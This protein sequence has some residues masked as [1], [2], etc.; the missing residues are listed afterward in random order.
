MS[1]THT[2]FNSS[3][4]LL[5]LTIASLVCS[6]A[7]AD[8]AGRV[9]FVLGAVNAI[10]L[11]GSTRKLAKSDLVYSGERL[12][13]GRGRLQ[14]RFTDGSFVSLQP[15]TVFRLDSYSFDKTAPEQGSLQFNFLRGGLRTVT[16]AIGKVNRA[17]YT[18]RSPVATIGIRGTG[19]ATTL[20]N[21]VLTL[22]V[23]KGIVNLSN[24][25]G[26][27]NISAGQT[28]QVE[29]GEAPHLAPPGV[30]AV[31]LAQTPDANENQQDD[32]LANLI[33]SS[34]NNNDMLAGELFLL[35]APE[36]LSPVLP[37]S[38][39]P[40]QSATPLPGYTFASRFYQNDNKLYINQ[41]GGFFNNSNDSA[42]GGLLQLTTSASNRISTLFN[43]G[44][45][46]N[47]GLH[48]SH[49]RTLGALSFGEWTNGTAA[50]GRLD[51]SDNNIVLGA[52]EFEPYIIGLNGEASLGMDNQGNAIKLNYSL[53]GA[54]PARSTN[55]EIG[56][57]SALN[58]DLT[59]SPLVMMNIFMTVDMA[60]TGQYSLSRNN[61]AINNGNSNTLNSFQLDNGE[62][63][64]TGQNCAN[65]GCPVTL[66]A[67]LAGQNDLGA[68]YTI[69]RIGDQIGG[70]GALT[71]TS[72]NTVPVKLVDT[73]TPNYSAVFSGSADR[74]LH[75]ENSIDAQFD[76]MGAW[77]SGVVSSGNAYGPAETQSANKAQA[78][79]T[80]HVAQTLA[81]GRWANG[82]I[83]CGGSTLQLNNDG[84]HYVVGT[85]TTGNFPTAKLSYDL[86]GGTSPTAAT[87]AGTLLAT[88]NLQS[89]TV[90]IDFGQQTATLQMGLGFNNGSS[91]T[92]I[93]VNGTGSLDSGKLSFNDMTVSV[94]TG[95]NAPVNC[96]NC[97]ANASG[98]VA[99]I[100]ADMVGI[101]YQVQGVTI[102]Q[103]SNTT[104]TGVG[105]FANKH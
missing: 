24:D 68:I 102:G 16:G 47:N 4:R 85:P 92:G 8:I 63:R 33:N 61:I 43:A 105:A 96:S 75:R 38:R 69:D 71:E 76:D 93:N 64:A 86:V 1:G 9:S 72:T 18:V 78:V 101:G 36:E 23:D 65:G 30:N 62:L 79:N 20:L 22:S 7:L 82:D 84:M 40:A 103:S 11:D 41:V 25:F 46:N 59:L 37:D 94:S 95:S 3:R 67:F 99:G 83:S 56:R 28:F 54:T 48:F 45:V 80:G 87:S 44:D 42:R 14:I 26:S 100:N 6:E 19:Y 51:A 97:N 12:E 27:S 90:S 73:D 53:V 10:S 32:V 70:V 39:Y 35:D 58:I 29:P 21:G 104:V 98:F 77:Q 13:T 81:W 88:G 55:G 2:A 52:N 50:N 89:G 49:V 91:A 60:Q 31:A 66:A 57:L 15:D 5:A 34:L 74:F 17:R